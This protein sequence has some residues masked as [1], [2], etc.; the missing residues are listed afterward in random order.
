MNY[1]KS[2]PLN[3]IFYLFGMVID[4]PIFVGLLVK[5]FQNLNTSPG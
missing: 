1:E 2:L 5:T 4:I 3:H